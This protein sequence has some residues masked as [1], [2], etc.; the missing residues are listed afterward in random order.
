[1]I[2]EPFGSFDYLFLLSI[3]FVSNIIYILTI[4]F[5][6]SIMKKIFSRVFFSS[7][8]LMASG[9]L[10]FPGSAAAQDKEKKMEPLEYGNRKAIQT[11]VINGTDQTAV[12][13]VDALNLEADQPISLKATAGFSV[14]PETLPADTKK[15]KVMV[16]LNSSK[17]ESKGQV[18]I[19]S[20]DIRY[21]LNVVGYGSSLTPKDLSKKPIYKGGNDS[22][23][24]KTV[25]DGFKP[26]GNG[27][28]IE[29]RV[30]T[31]D[32]GM[33]FCPY[34]VNENG[35]GFKGFVTN[36][37]LGLY[38]EKSQ[39]EFSNPQTSAEGGLSKFYNE[40]GRYHTYRYAV[41]ADN[42]MFIYR[43][44]SLV[45]I[46]RPADYGLSANLAGEPGEVVEN[47]LKNANFEGQFDYTEEDGPLV[48]GI[49]GW[50][51]VIGDKYN[52]EQFIV[53]QEIDNVLDMDNHILRLQ[54]YRWS[55]GWS[56]G[57]IKQTVDV[58]PNETY[59]LSA[60]M[61]GGIK[62]E[63]Q[64]LGKILIEE[65]QDTDLN[66]ST[67]V[68]SNTWETYSLDYTTSGNC[69]QIAVMFYLERDKWGAEITPLEA[70]NVKLT[71]KSR[72]YTPKTGFENKAAEIEYFT[73]DL[74][75]AY[76]PEQPEIVIGMDNK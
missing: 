2:R 15:A 40:D 18:I 35:V 52:S 21:Y 41:T 6:K 5:Y 46:T 76:A 25:N 59:T 36:K 4:S 10:I 54:R 34:A 3:K 23:F 1:M 72:L 49:E 44:G 19:R 65:V 75:G 50:D 22:K 14:S 20:G 68:T 24:E 55:D 13:T 27:F 53:R 58:V 60:L 8:L 67:D 63:G 28:T 69:K 74:T 48:K 37:G 66:T 47:L 30:K 33:E 17:P 57:L 16:R 9:I 73:Y 61:R 7:F 31:D 51:I 45:K 12:F 43:D 42:S 64:I 70:D 38:S 62:K 26:T 71:G 39:K 29:F 32:S 11:L 56:A